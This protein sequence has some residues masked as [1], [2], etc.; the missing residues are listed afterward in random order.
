MKVTLSYALVSVEDAPVWLD[1]IGRY[2]LMTRKTPEEI[3]REK[4]YKIRTHRDK[5]KVNKYRFEDKSVMQRDPNNPNILYFMTGL[6]PKVKDALDEHGETYEIV[7]MRDPAKKP[8]IDFKAIEGTEFRENQDVALAMIATADCGIINTSVGF[9]K[10][11]LIAVICKAFP[12]LNI[13]VTTD[14]ASVV[15]TNYEYIKKV[16]PKEVGILKNGK[17]TTLGKRII[18]TTL[19]SLSKIPTTEVDLL[20]VDEC[21]AIGDNLAGETIKKFYFARKFGFSA[22]PIRNDGSGIVLES[23]LGPVILQMSYQEAVAAGMVTPMK[24]VMLPCYRGAA[25]LKTMSKDNDAVLKRLS[26]WNNFGR[27]QIIAEFV[28][29]LWNTTDAQMLII[30]GK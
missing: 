4:E 15:E 7:D 3:K 12:T 5:I 21:H 27:N 13:V 18:V 16:L 20:L 19:K 24:Y 22:T 2:K 25:A 1:A 6:W 28:R 23:L 8:A 11:W 26:Y 30:V 10:T 29:D 17:D 14:S 9:G